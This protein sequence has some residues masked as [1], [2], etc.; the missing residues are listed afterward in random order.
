[1][2]RSLVHVT[3]TAFPIARRTTLCASTLETQELRCRDADDPL[4]QFHRNLIRRH[5]NLTV[6]W[7]G[8]GFEFPLQAAGSWP[9]I[10]LIR[11]WLSELKLL[12]LPI[13][14]R[15]LVTPN[16]L[17]GFPSIHRHVI[18]NSFINISTILIGPAFF[19]RICI[20]KQDRSYS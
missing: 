16:P 3:G 10:I 17:L 7:S 12:C 1:M 11:K 5:C 6:D 15:N 8:L 14:P 9:R 4:W 20:N 13:E 19:K 2:A 18:E